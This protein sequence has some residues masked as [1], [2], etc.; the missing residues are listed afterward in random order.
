[1]RILLPIPFK[2]ITYEGA[3]DKVIHKPFVSCSRIAKPILGTLRRQRSSLDIYSFLREVPAPEFLRRYL[4][5]SVFALLVELV[6]GDS[7]V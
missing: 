4:S 5:A 2:H 7:K 1:M 3:K 6:Y